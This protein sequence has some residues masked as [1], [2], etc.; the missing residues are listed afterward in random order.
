MDKIM[1][2]A[3]HFASLKSVGSPISERM[4]MAELNCIN[5]GSIIG[6]VHDQLV[7]VSVIKAVGT[8]C[9]AIDPLHTDVDRHCAFQV[10]DSTSTTCNIWSLDNGVSFM[11]NYQT[12]SRFVLQIESP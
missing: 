12:V 10:P 3:P 9:P 2:Q 4:M 6:M 1:T 7:C 8:P 11:A 5:Q